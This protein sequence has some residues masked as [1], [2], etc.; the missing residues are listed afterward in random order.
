MRRA[1]V[2]SWTTLPRIAGIAASAASASLS[3]RFLGEYELPKAIGVKLAAVGIVN[4]V[5]MVVVVAVSVSV[6]DT[7]L[8]TVGCQRM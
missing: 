7:V 8:V 5:G 1:A 6:V 4:T 3:E 2:R